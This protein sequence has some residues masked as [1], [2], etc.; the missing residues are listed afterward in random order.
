M[1][2]HCKFHILSCS[3]KSSRQISN[4]IFLYL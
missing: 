1:L 2:L 4:F 3:L